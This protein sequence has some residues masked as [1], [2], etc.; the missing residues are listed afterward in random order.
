M[1][2]KALTKNITDHSDTEHFSFSFFCDQCGKEW[3]SPAVPF[4]SGGFSAIDHKETKALI[5]AK[6][7]QLAFDRANLE[8]H[9]EF[10]HC[11]SCNRWLCDACFGIDD[12]LSE[13]E[14]G[15]RKCA[16]CKFK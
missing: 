4:V 13:P 3:V 8:A 11:R 10:N 7:H 5:W 15:V 2:G 12:N 1:F 9:L 16:V 6:E 14:D